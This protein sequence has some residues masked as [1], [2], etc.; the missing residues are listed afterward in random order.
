M[1]LPVLHLL[2]LLAAAAQ[3]PAAPH[4][5]AVT[6]RDGIHLATDVYG[7]AAGAREPVLLMR[8]P[9]NKRGAKAIAE[10]FTAGGYVAVVQDTRGAYASEG[11]YVHYNNDDQ[12][13]FDTIEW[14]VQQPWSNGK[15][16]MWG[17][18]HPGAVQWVAAADRAYGLLA[19]APTGGPEQFLPHHVPGRRAPS[20]AHGRR[21]SCH[22][23]PSARDHRA[24]RP[25]SVALSPAARHPRRSYRLV[26]AMA[27]KRGQA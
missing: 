7:E 22:Q 11:K 4:V 8:T 14:I 12:D 6:M 25:H 3:A 26:D 24:Q 9:Y 15:V 20:R 21:G 10:R 23:S 13:G 2:V 17:A 18:S 16:G 27:E 1:N 19:I 5:Y